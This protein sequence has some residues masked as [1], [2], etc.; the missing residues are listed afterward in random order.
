MLRNIVICS[1]SLVVAATLSAQPRTVLSRS[2]LD[3]L[4]F[5]A[6]STEAQGALC[7]TPERYDVGTIDDTRSVEARYTLTNTTTKDITITDIR[8]MCSCVKVESRIG[9]IPAG[10]SADICCSFNPH[11]RK[12]VFGYEI[13]VYTSLDA[14]HPTARISLT[15]EVRP[16]DEWLHLRYTAGA[17]RYGRREVTFSDNT[18]ERIP[19]ANT[20]DKPLTLSSRTTVDGLALRTEPETI[21]PKSEAVIII[22]YKPKRQT[23]MKLRTMLMLEGIDAKPTDRMITVNIDK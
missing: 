7:A 4:V 21:E 17:L 14:E 13:M 6:L 5:P 10:K 20:S 8:P 11:G 22:S 18:I 15:G 3:E 12:G 19:C 1:L 9:T 23:T 2:A 16:T